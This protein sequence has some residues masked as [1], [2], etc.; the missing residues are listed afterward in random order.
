M[1]KNDLKERLDSLGCV[2]DAPQLAR[3]H[4]I[5]RNHG[6][7]HETL[8]DLSLLTLTVEAYRHPESKHEG[9]A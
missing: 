1:Q 2:L 8:T 6:V 5:M 7:A 9:V 3:A 4:E